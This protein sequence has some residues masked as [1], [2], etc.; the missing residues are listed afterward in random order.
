MIGA[1]VCTLAR[2]HA[3]WT[4]STCSVTPGGVGGALEERGLD[5][6]ALDPPLDVVDEVLGDQVHV[7]VLEVVG[8]VVIAVDTGARRRC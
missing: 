8:Q 7:A 2:A 3:R 6:G 5:V 1:P 4:F